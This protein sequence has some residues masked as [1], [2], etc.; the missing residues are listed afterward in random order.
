[1]D[2]EEGFKLSK[3][4]NSESSLSRHSDWY[5]PGKS[6]EDVEKNMKRKK[7]T[8]SDSRDT[9]LSNTVKGYGRMGD[10]TV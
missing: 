1:M 5:I 9:R 8:L 10:P 3:A 6:Q 4:W 7:Q 2:T